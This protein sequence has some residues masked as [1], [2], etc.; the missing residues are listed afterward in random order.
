VQQHVK[1]KSH[2]TAPPRTEEEKLQ[3]LPGNHSFV[4]HEIAG[5]RADA[6]LEIDVDVDDEVCVHSSVEQEQKFPGHC[7]CVKS[8]TKRNHDGYVT[9]EHNLREIPPLVKF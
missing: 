2:Q 6:R 1:E 4:Y 3:D 7:V 5:L 9:Q 8:N